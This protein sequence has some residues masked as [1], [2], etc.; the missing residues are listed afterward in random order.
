M[1]FDAH[2]HIIAPEFPLIENKG[3]LPEYF[4]ISE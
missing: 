2:F 1:I 3:F 4:T